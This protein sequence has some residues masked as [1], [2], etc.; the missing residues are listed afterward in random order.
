MIWM[1]FES[2]SIDNRSLGSNLVPRLSFV[3]MITI[4]LILRMFYQTSLHTL[5]KELIAV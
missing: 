4:Y 3:S 1:I 5:G 2:I